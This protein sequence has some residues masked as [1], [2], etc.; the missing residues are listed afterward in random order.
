MSN[1]LEQQV[2]DLQKKLDLSQTYRI[3][4]E[5]IN[6]SVINNK[7]ILKVAKSPELLQQ[8]CVDIANF[9][10]AKA[11]SIETGQIYEDVSLTIDDIKLV[12]KILEKFEE[13]NKQNL[14]GGSHGKGA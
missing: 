1:V 7:K 3:L 2:S 11:V 6:Q 5:F 13:R 9:A 12:K 14:K 4:S 10:V 8:V